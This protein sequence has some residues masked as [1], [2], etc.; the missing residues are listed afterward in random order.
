MNSLSEIARQVFKFLLHFGG[1]GNHGCSLMDVIYAGR[2][3]V[4]LAGRPICRQGLGP[5]PKCWLIR[6]PFFA[7]SKLKVLIHV[8]FF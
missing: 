8:S 6:D 1:T 2:R 7:C 4:V 5:R 3:R